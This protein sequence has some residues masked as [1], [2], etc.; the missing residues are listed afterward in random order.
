MSSAS[1]PITQQGLTGVRPIQTGSSGINRIYKDKRYYMSLMQSHMN[2]IREELAN[3]R[4]V[5]A[6]HRTT[7]LNRLEAR[8][9]AEVSARNYAEC[10]EI[11][12]VYNVVLEIQ[13]SQDK[14]DKLAFETT[15]LKERN[16][17]VLN[18]LD[19]LVNYKVRRE[20][21]VVALKKD[22]AQVSLVNYLLLI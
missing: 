19:V 1:R 18:E 20:E 22:M 10:Q 13:N 4:K 3:L 14:I 15:T 7:S 5:T 8:K 12:S 11:L 21:K 17:H 2:S 6:D 9:T 16:K